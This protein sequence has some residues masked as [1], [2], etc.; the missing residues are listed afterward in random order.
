M[1]SFGGF[2]FSYF[3]IIII[4]G[5]LL[6]AYMFYYNK[7]LKKVGVTAR[8]FHPNGASE[9]LPAK[10]IFTENRLEIIK[11]HG[12]GGFL[13]RNK[14]EAEVMSVELAG[15]PSEHRIGASKRER[16]YYVKIGVDKT[17]SFMTADTMGDPVNQLILQITGQVKAAGEAMHSEGKK[18]FMN[19]LP[20]IIM[21]SGITF[22]ALYFLK[23]AFPGVAF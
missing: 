5:F 13:G 3:D 8:L 7:T 22:M 2:G 6:V 11:T 20:G 18:G 9:D 10:E 17:L 15:W 1:V 23:L 12:S 16:T 4:G 19:S 14:T 21:G